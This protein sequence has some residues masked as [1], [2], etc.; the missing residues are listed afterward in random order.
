MK[1]ILVS[2]LVSAVVSAGMF[3]LLGRLAGPGGGAGASANLVDVPNLSGL[4]A[5]QARQLLEPRGLL[6]EL[7]EQVEDS[8]YPAG[9]ISEQSPLSGSRLGRGSPVRAKVVKAVER[10]KVPALAGRGEPEARAMLE[11]VRLKAG[12]RA[13][14]TTDGGAA[15]VVLATTPPPGAE[16]PPG[17]AVELT[18]SAQAQAT[19]PRVTGRGLAAAKQALAKAGFALGDVRHGSD[20]DVGDGVVLR[21]TPAAETKAPAGSK[22]DLVVN[23]TD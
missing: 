10:V 18:V 7:T 20:E 4:T 16:V 14:R 17:S 19:V 6:L 15:G 12:A 2:A 9:A 5:D 11:A 23:N 1:S 3:F 13:E 8:R 21:Q 22:V